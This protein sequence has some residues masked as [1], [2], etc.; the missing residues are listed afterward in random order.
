LEETLRCAHRPA[1]N[2]AGLLWKVTMESW[3]SLAQTVHLFL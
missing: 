2:I 1:V 3:L